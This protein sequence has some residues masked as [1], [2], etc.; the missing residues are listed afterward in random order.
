MFCCVVPDLHFP[1][2]ISELSVFSM[3]IFRFVL[4]FSDRYFTNCIFYLCCSIC[5]RFLDMYF[6]ILQNVRMGH[7][8]KGA[9]LSVET[10]MAMRY[11]TNRTGL[12]RRVNMVIQVMTAKVTCQFKQ[13]NVII[14][15]S[16]V[17]RRMRYL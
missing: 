10:V 3:C 11:V 13:T 16:H 14:G 7:M 5:T 6:P 12:V 17:V 9:S 15:P 1:I 2:C 4:F 8:A